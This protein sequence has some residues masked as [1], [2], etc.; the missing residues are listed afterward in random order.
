M[1]AYTPSPEND[2]AL[3][4]WWQTMM[5]SGDIHD[6]PVE[7]RTLSC[8]YESLQPPTTLLTESD[9]QG[10]WFCFWFTP[11]SLPFATINLWIRQDYRQKKAAIKAVHVAIAAAFQEHATLVA[12]CGDPKISALYEGFGLGRHHPDIYSET[13]QIAVFS[14]TRE[15]YHQIEKRSA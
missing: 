5:N 2:V 6:Y 9:E 7:L 11:N 8:F 4:V 14:L 12:Y 13:H 1:I 3:F 15:Q 10:L